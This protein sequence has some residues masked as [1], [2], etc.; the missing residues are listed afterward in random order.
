MI[1]FI[2]FLLI[3]LLIIFILFYFNFIDFGAIYKD[4]DVE[5]NVIGFGKAAGLYLILMDGY[6]IVAGQK[7]KSKKKAIKEFLELVNNNDIDFKDFKILR[8]N[9]QILSKDNKISLE[10]VVEKNMIK[11]SQIQYLHEKY[12][13]YIQEKIK[14]NIN[15]QNINKDIQKTKDITK[16][17]EI[18]INEPEV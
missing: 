11:E 14:N 13:K 8:T 1:Y 2:L 18:H 9:N 7:I 12:Q 15:N 3:A 4:F 5:S 10:A 6:Y 16:T 17:K